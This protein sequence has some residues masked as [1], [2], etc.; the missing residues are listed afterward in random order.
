MGRPQM[1]SGTVSNS[2]SAWRSTNLFC[3]YL[4]RE[5]TSTPVL[6]AKH[7]SY[8]GQTTVFL[9]TLA[10]EANEFDQGVLGDRSFECDATYPWR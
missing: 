4:F 9:K 5:S 8:L 7:Q 2:F 3:F 1:D 6:A 10:F